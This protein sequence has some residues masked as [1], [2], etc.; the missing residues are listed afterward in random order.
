ME[1]SFSDDDND[2]PSLPP[3]IMLDFAPQSEDNES[4][5]RVVSDLT[6]EE[7]LPPPNIH[8]ESEGSSSSSD[9]DEKQET[10]EDIL[11]FSNT[12]EKNFGK[13][14]ADIKD[15]LQVNNNTLITI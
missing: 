12:K 9:S 10:A 11:K 6:T 15:E 13:A 1:D 14:K 3:S 5:F 4:K 8:V 2:F 7:E